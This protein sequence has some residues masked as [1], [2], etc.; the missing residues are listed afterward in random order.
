MSSVK[1]RSAVVF[2]YNIVLISKNSNKHMAHLPLVLTLFSDAGVPIKKKIFLFF[3]EKI[4]ILDHIIRAGR[5]EPSEATTATVRQLKASRTKTE[6][7]YFLGPLQL[8]QACGCELL[9][10]SNTVE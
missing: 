10:S 6:L 3:D 9:K 7:R 2:L 8:V 4:N 5:A 1:G